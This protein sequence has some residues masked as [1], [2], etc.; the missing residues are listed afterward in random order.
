MVMLTAPPPDPLHRA[1]GDPPQVSL[2]L[3]LMVM[4]TAPPP[5]PLH[6]APA[7][8]GHRLL[9]L[10]TGAGAPHVARQV[11]VTLCLR[12]G[13]GSQLP[14]APR[15]LTHADQPL[16]L[17]ALPLPLG[18]HPLMLLK[19]G[20]DRATRAWALGAAPLPAPPVLAPPVAP[21]VNAP[22]P[23]PHP[24]AL[25]ALGSRRSGGGRGV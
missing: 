13:L 4:L 7:P 18:Q 14:P 17:P 9:L 22:P 2:T 10:H 1:P 3:R 21:L 12:H 23:L 24:L 19:P 20:E 25:G 15:P 5:D 16:L 8:R 6:R 11:P